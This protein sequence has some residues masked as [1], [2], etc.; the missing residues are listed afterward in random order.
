MEKAALT[1]LEIL[2]EIVATL[3]AECT[4]ADLLDLVGKLLSVNHP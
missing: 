3:V 2:R 1:Q 4:D